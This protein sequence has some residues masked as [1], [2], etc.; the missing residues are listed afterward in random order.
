M[1]KCAKCGTGWTSSGLPLC[2]V[3]GT[4]VPERTPDPV[5]LIE[6]PPAEPAPRKSGTAI[7]PVPVMEKEAAVEPEPRLR[8][9]DPSAENIPVQKDLPSPKRPLVGPLVLGALAFVPALLLPLTAAFEDSRVLG[10]LGFCMAGFFAPFAPIAWMVGLGAEKR[11][12]DQGLRP[13]RTVTPGRTLGQLATL[14]RVGE[15]TV[16]F[17]ALAALRLSGKCPGSFWS[18]L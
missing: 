10:V 16:G 2:P 9:V 6:M 1:V 12:R 17:L 3:C 4:R 14:V 13:E 7:L 8:L 5:P 18:Y 15:V 11:R